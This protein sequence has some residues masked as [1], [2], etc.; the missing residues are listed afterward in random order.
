MLGAGLINKVLATT[1][2]PLKSD[3]EIVPRCA[4]GHPG[5]GDGPVSA[6]VH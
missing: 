4:C 1:A 5:C 6:E 2:V 3:D